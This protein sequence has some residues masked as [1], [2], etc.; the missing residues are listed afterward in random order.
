[1]LAGKTVELTPVFTPA[2]GGAPPAAPQETDIDW[3][4][5][6]RG[7]IEKSAPAQMRGTFRAPPKGSLAKP[8]TVLVLAQTKGPTPHI[9]GADVTILPDISASDE[10]CTSSRTVTGLLALVAAFG[11]LGGLTHGISSFSTYA[12]N[13]ELLP[14]W[15]WWYV[16]KPFLGALVAVVVFLVARAGFGPGISDLSSPNCL[17]AGALAALVGLFAEPA[18][19]K[20]RDIFD[21]LFT[22]RQ[23]PRRDAATAAG[24]KQAVAPKLERLDP[25]TVK[26]RQSP[27]PLLRVIGT[28]FAPDCKAKV[29]AEFRS[30]AYASATELHV[31]LLPADIEKP[32]VLPVIVY[33]QPP[34]GLPSSSLTLKVEA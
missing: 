7:D 29:G 20:L 17:T 28:G 16:F 3:L 27:T 14:S 30:T 24:K 6:A 22:P 21:S 19:I 31:S 11:A 34:D 18:T 23:D 5:P 1:V 26:A 10:D 9:A 13:R 33:N 8:V 32:G 2:A 15:I 12:G 4:K 25:E